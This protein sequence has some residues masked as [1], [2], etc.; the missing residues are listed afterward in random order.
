MNLLTDVLQAQ[1]TRL[2]R[3]MDALPEPREGTVVSL[4]PLEVRF[5]R[6]TLATPVRWSVGGL[7]VG[8]V[9]QTL[10]I[11]RRVAV[12]G[13]AGGV[14]PVTV[15]RVV[16]TAGVSLSNT[17]QSVPGLSVSL[18]LR[19][20]DTVQVTAV[21]D[22]D[23]SSNI[24]V[25]RLLV[26]GAVQTEEAHAQYGGRSTV[27]QV[28]VWTATTD[29]AHTF[30]PRVAVLSGSAELYKSHTTMSLLVIPN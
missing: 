29:G 2:S 7:A 12:I 15:S 13:R 10:T 6:D 20:G 22:Q 19:A 9:V 11:N 18:E 30:E 17:F 4:S 26:D 5:P 27:S 8:D 25:G 1:I 24:F 23:T 16:A 28:W 21:F 14:R 3:R